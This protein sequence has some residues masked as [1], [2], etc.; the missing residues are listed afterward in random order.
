MIKQAIGLSRFALSTPL[1]NVLKVEKIEEVYMKQK[2][3]FFKQI[4]SNK[5]SRDVF[6][7]LKEFYP[8]NKAPKE[9]FNR[10]LELVNRR[11]GFAISLETCKKALNDISEIFSCKNSGLCE[12]ISFLFSKMDRDKGDE[13]TW[14]SHRQALSALLNN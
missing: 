7:F 14:K 8:R 4:M 2:L 13:D 10:Q 12:S 11:I 9:S 1:L 6:I 3:Y 5:L